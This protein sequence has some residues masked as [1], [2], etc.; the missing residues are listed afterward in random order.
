MAVASARTASPHRLGGH[1]LAVW[2]GAFITVLFSALF[3]ARSAFSYEGK[4]YFSLFDDSMISMRYGRSLAEGHGLVWNPGGERV[5][6]FTNLLWTLWM[7]L[8]HLVGAPDSSSSLVIMVTGVALLVANLLV[9]AA[10]ARRLAPDAPRV[11]VLS[12]LATALLYPLLFWTLRGME[13]G[14]LAL[15]VSLATLLAL[16]VAERA[17]P[18]DIAALSAVLVAGILTRDDSFTW[19]AVIV[20]FVAWRS[21][22][23]AAYLVAALVVAVAAKTGFRLAYYDAALPNTYHLKLDGEPLGARIGRGLIAV[24]NIALVELFAPIALALV[25]LRDARRSPALL[26]IAALFAV[27]CAYSVYVGGD[28]WEFLEFTNRYITPVLPVFLVLAAIGLH[29]L[30][31]EGGRVAWAL[32]AAFAAV[33]V[34]NVA[35]AESQRAFAELVRIGPP[36]DRYAEVALALVLAAAA[37]AVGAHRRAGTGA[38]F[39]IGAVL[40]I[41]AISGQQ[42]VHW[43][44]NGAEYAEADDDMAR[45]GLLLGEA[46][47]PQTTIA[48]TWAGAIPYFSR[49]PT[50]DLLG[51][52]D[53]VIARQAPRDVP[54][55]PGHDKFDYEHSLGRLRPQLV[56]Q[57]WFVGPEPWG[58]MRRWG[59]TQIAIQ[60]LPLSQWAQVYVTRDV[61]ASVQQELK[62]RLPEIVG[63]S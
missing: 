10:I 3:I 15:L 59:Y 58:P 37:A 24:V 46:T 40:L 13:V 5:E 1:R 34:V 17:S 12:V 60:K 21:R 56:A 14:L 9:V 18:R 11:A 35:L 57:L 43:A 38:A 25:A 31:Q 52:S 32:A 49:R 62:R 50:V 48:V 54:F 41:A 51:K 53:P 47:P 23:A 61:P 20:L 19:A 2:A 44:Q 29:R 33:A 27:Q 7:A 63:D 26:L 4:T 8:V 6:G 42:L 36:A 30:L 55:T 39:A 16:R 45:Y 22:A 28:V